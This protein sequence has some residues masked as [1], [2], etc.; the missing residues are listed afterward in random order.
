MCK[1][2]KCEKQVVQRGVCSEHYNLLRM[3]V[4]KTLTWSALELLGLTT[5]K[6]SEAFQCKS[7]GCQAQFHKANGYCSKHYQGSRTERVNNQC[8]YPAC[9][10]PANCA[11][12]EVNGQPTVYLHNGKRY[13]PAHLNEAMHGE[14]I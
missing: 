11:G 1:F 7:I 10:K 13:C 8:E 12:T 4:G 3:F 5:E 14:L 9:D 2:H 6:V